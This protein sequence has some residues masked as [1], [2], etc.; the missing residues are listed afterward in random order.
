[1]HRPP[2][3][4]VPEEPQQSLLPVSAKPILHQGEVLQ[5][6]ADYKIRARLLLQENY[7]FDPVS[8]LAPTDLCV[9][10]GPLSDSKNIE[11]LHLSQTMRFCFYYWS[12]APPVDEQTIISSIANMHIIPAN[13][14]VKELLSDLRPGQIL[15]LTGKLVRVDKRDG[16][17]WKSSLSRTDTGDGACEIMYVQGLSIEE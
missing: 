6:L 7:H 5:P 2:G 4:L 16:S 15:T 10:W 13:A 12:G 11:R 9:A 14:A 3:I 1:M 8:K 17:E